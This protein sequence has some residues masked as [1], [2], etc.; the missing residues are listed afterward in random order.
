M[1][2]SWNN[3][4]NFHEPVKLPGSKSIAARA[5]ILSHIF[6]ERIIP[7]NL[8]DCDDT[9]ELKTALD[10]LKSG[11]KDNFYESYNLGSGGTSLRFFLAYVS[12]VDGFKGIVDCSEEL[13]RRPLF[14]LI[15]ALRI[16]GAHIEY[17]GKE[18]CPPLKVS[19]RKLESFEGMP[20]GAISSQYASALMMSSLLWEKEFFLPQKNDS[21]SQSYLEMTRHMIEEFKKIITTQSGTERYAYNIESDWSA[22]SYF[23]EFAL[24]CPGREVNLY[25]LY[26]PTRSLQGDSACEIIF[27]KLGVET[28]F[29][30]KGFLKLKGNADEIRKVIRN[31][32]IIDLNLCDTP[33]LV[34]AL[35]VGMCLAGIKFHI[36]GIGHLRFKE[37]D[38]LAALCEELAKLG[39]LLENDNESLAWLGKRL[40]IGGDIILNSHGDH[41]MAMAL[42]MASARYMKIGI[43]NSDCVTKS[44]PSYFE[45][46]RKLGFA[47]TE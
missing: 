17:I 2:I 35:A 27:G 40:E 45:N 6:D 22:A 30:P 34:P 36:T 42:S 31:E 39:Y 26:A 10:Q 1:T 32:K 14:P 8:P 12:S 16:A 23:Y 41:R 38:R 3:G 25:N 24:L 43:V 47:V 9:T 19:G 20:G 7:V 13:R 4:Y 33:D 11:N 15:D 44:F 37:S 29:C 18:G 28:E 21:V 46:L 5:L